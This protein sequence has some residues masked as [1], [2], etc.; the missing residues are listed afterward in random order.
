MTFSEFSPGAD[1]YARP[2]GIDSG[3]YLRIR[4]MR[5]VERA[6]SPIIDHNIGLT[7]QAF[8]VRDWYLGKSSEPPPFYLSLLL[9]PVRNAM[10]NLL[11]SFAATVK[12]FPPGAFPG[13]CHPVRQL[14][15]TTRYL[16]NVLSGLVV[17]TVFAAALKQL[18]QFFAAIS[19][20]ANSTLSRHDLALRIDAKLDLLLTTFISICRAFAQREREIVFAALPRED[21]VARAVGD[22]LD[23]TRSIMVKADVILDTATGT[24]KI[25]DRIDARSVRRGKR[26]REIE[27]QETCFRYWEIARTKSAVIA[28]SNKKVSYAAAFDYFKRELDGYGVRS[29]EDFTRL[30]Q[31]RS[32]RVSIQARRSKKTESS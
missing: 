32:K 18:G 16:I 4:Q 21:G 2:D 31:R 6:A 14:E 11:V 28:G 12:E 17:S 15:F 24:R 23:S 7:E 1:L 27:K 5:P 10:S 25:V 19:D 29:A 22:I 26:E 9:D 30:L 13:H 3:S 8:Q 20:P